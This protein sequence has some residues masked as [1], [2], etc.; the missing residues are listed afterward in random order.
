MI[1][2]IGGEKGGTGKTTVSTN[3]AVAFIHNKLDFI[4]I[5]SDKQASF[6][7]WATIRNEKMSEKIYCISKYGDLRNDIRGLSQKY[8]NIIIDIGGRDTMEFRT[9][10][11]VCDCVYIPML[12]SQFDMW[13]MGRIQNAI[14]D[15]MPLNPKLKAIL[16]LNRVPTNPQIQEKD[17]VKALDGELQ[18]ISIGNT[19]IYE[20]IVYRKAAK[21]GLGVLELDDKKAK[22]EITNLYEEIMN[23]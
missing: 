22:I 15:A 7:D 17:E 14:N 12:A 10:L 1:I 19:L 2:L 6:S 16:I 5:D 23:G 18:N 8:Q 4:I 13:T 9:A 3:L 11:T 21:D 20:R